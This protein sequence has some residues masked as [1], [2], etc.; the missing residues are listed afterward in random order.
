MILNRLVSRYSRSQGSAHRVVYKGELHTGRSPTACLA[1]PSEQRSLTSN[2]FTV[3]AHLSRPLAQLAAS[4]VGAMSHDHDIATLELDLV[5]QLDGGGDDRRAALAALEATPSPI[6]KA[7]ALAF[8]PALANIFATESDGATF[9]R[10]ALL[11]VRAIDDAAQNGWLRSSGRADSESNPLPL[12]RAMFGW[13][14]QTQ[15]GTAR[16][17]FKDGWADDSAVGVVLRRPLAEV[18][19]DDLLTFSYA[20]LS[21]VCFDGMQGASWSIDLAT[22]ALETGGF[23]EVFAYR[24]STELNSISQANRRTDG[25]A[26]AIAQRQL[27]AIREGPGK[28]LPNETAVRL[29][30]NSLSYTIWTT[31]GPGSP[32]EAAFEGGVFELA[33][34][35][36]RQVGSPAQW[37]SISE[38]RG[39]AT[40]AA[41]TVTEIMDC[42]GE[43]HVQMKEAFVSTGLFDEFIAALSAVEQRGAE[44]LRQDTDLMIM[45]HAVLKALRLFADDPVCE[46]KIRS[47]AAGLRLCLE[48]DATFLAEFGISTGSGS[49]LICARVF[50]RDEEHSDLGFTQPHVDNMLAQWKELMRPKH[51]GLKATPTPER[52]A[53]AGG[54]LRCT[55]IHPEFSAARIIPGEFS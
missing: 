14:R 43:L 29:M 3:G 23:Q 41:Y 45:T 44:L 48:V 6:P 31:S 20:I 16:V 32:A 25:F 46:R 52:C 38:G 17:P 5:A 53:A 10:T 27:A 18:S 54:M 1:V 34:A 28:L 15:E 21:D 36:I 47:V 42:S 55:R 35:R 22:K 19:A 7:T 40:G 11:M 2:Q 39:R 26:T 30:W 49:A 12:I 51:F 4:S 50:G 8:A 24:F 33:L 9:R 37:I 13:R